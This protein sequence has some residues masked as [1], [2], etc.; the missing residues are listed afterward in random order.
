M[1]RQKISLLL[2]L[3]APMASAE[4]IVSAKALGASIGSLVAIAAI[5]LLFA[6]IGL[7][8]RLASKATDGIKEG[9][10]RLFIVLGFTSSAAWLITLRVM[11]SYWNTK[12]TIFA[13]STAIMA[14]FVPIIIAKIIKWVSD[15]F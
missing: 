8:R 3:V 14:F 9:Y 15:G 1:M 10:I 11:D 6:L 7:F 5:M 13:I 4:P 2:M 12:E